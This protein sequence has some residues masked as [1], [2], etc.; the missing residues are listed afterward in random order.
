MVDE[1][2]K[3]APRETGA[4]DD[5]ESFDLDADADGELDPEA[6]IRDAVE[7]VEARQRGERRGGDSVDDGGREVEEEL[8]QTR[9]RLL[10]TMADFENYRKRIERDRLERDRYAAAE[11]LEQFLEVLDNLERALGVNG[12]SGDLRSGV[13]LIHRQ[14]LDL[15]ARF[16][17]RPVLA[18][19]EPFDPA[20]HEAVARDEDPNV[21]QPTVVEELQRGYR[22]HDRLLRPARVVVAMPA[23]ERER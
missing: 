13:E 8:E 3:R 19:G 1:D 10:R 2:R 9:D 7:A 12:E 11:A 23:D 21:E 14:M 15:L 22:F 17:V 20:V 16:E 18:Q 6:A 5:E 4:V